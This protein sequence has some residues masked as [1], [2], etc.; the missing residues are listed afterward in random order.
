[1]AS[2]ECVVAHTW[3]TKKIWGDKQKTTALWRTVDRLRK[4]LSEIS[5]TREYIEVERG[6]GYKFLGA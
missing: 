3:L 5:P 1:M 4:K 6:V 2:S